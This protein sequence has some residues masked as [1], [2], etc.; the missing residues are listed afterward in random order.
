M[1]TTVNKTASVGEL[2]I[3]LGSGTLTYLSTNPLVATVDDTG[4]ITALGTGT[5]SIVI[6][7]SGVTCQAIIT[8]IVNSAETYAGTYSINTTDGGPIPN[9]TPDPFN[10]TT[11]QSGTVQLAVSPSL[12]KAGAFNG[13]VTLG[14]GTLTLTVPS[15]TCTNPDGSITTVPGST[16]SAPVPAI[17]GT[18]TG[19]TDG[20]VIAIPVPGLPSITGTVTAAGSLN[21]SW[22]FTQSGSGVTDNIQISMSL[23]KQ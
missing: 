16:V 12:L 6:S 23:T 1:D 18:I 14:A 20:S 21:L 13:G 10:S 15:E 4:D 7:S 19:T 2:S 3:T 8:V 5:T 17:S 11:S 9:C 22:N